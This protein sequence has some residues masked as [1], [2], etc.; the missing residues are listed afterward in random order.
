M[1]D[2]RDA[3][4]AQAAA[5]PAEP[6]PALGGNTAVVGG[7]GG[8]QLQLV[9]ALEIADP[10]Q[11]PLVLVGAKPMGL[12][13]LGAA[14]D[15]DEQEQ[16]QRLGPGAA[17]QS[18][19]FVELI[20][21]VA[22]NRGVDLQAGAGCAE[23]V[24]PGQGAVERTGNA[25]KS[26]VRGGVGAVEAFATSPSRA[27]WESLDSRARLLVER[28]GDTPVGAMF[29]SILSDLQSRWKTHAGGEEARLQRDLLAKAQKDFAAG[30]LGLAELWISFLKRESKDEA[31]LR[32]AENLLSRIRTRRETQRKILIGS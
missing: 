23:V 32:D 16:V 14:A 31:L 12:A 17:G 20:E 13:Q 1:A 8:L 27:V 30:Q 22:R 6:N 11:H 24:G 10:L 25:T 18:G 19:Q 21:V 5:A 7:A 26:I 15:R 4:A 2:E 29:R 28:Y 3:R 9:V